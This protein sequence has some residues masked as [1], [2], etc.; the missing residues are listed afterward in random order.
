LRGEAADDRWVMVR[1]P[2]GGR[3]KKTS[4]KVKKPKYES[5][6]EEAWKGAREKR[7]AKG[8]QAIEA[9]GPHSFWRVSRFTIRKE[10]KRLWLLKDGK[11]KSLRGFMT[12]GYAERREEAE[13]ELV[14]DRAQVLN[15]GNGRTVFML[16]DPVYWSGEECVMQPGKRRHTSGTVGECDRGKKGIP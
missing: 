7:E 16:I 9:E 6:Q 13:G 14:C 8:A 4:S 11:G 12:T 5:I 15:R 2:I 10:K 3:K 1:V